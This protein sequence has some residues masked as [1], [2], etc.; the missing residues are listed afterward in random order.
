M[1][2]EVASPAAGGRRFVYAYYGYVD[3]IAHERGFG[4]FY[5][6]ELRTADR[7]VA[8]VL[9]LLPPGA[10]LLV[11][12]DHGQVEVGD[13]IVY[14][15]GRVARRCARCSRARAASVGC[16][17]DAGRPT[18]CWRRRPTSSATRVGGVARRQ[19]IAERWFGPSVPPKVANRLGDVAFVAYEPVSYHDPDDQGPFALVCRHGSLTSAEVNVPLLAGSN[20]LI[21]W[22]RLHHERRSETESADAELRRRRA[23]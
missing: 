13:R 14:P 20:C 21:G 1:P 15:L 23:R 17:P 8:D 16:T 4:D 3:K 9:E 19:M 6:A 22:I 5:D 12:A 10:V 11:T 18:I 2:I 7:L